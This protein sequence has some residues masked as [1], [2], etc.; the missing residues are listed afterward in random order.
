[1]IDKVW[2][3]VPARELKIGNRAQN[4]QLKQND[5]DSRQHERT[6]SEIVSHKPLN[7]VY[8]QQETLQNVEDEFTLLSRARALDQEALTQIHDRYYDSIYRYIA[9]R[10]DDPHMAEDLA[11]DVFLR[12][13]NA[14]QDKHAPQNT[15]RGWLYGVASNVVKEYYRKKRRAK[16]TEL[17]ESTPHDGL[18]PEQH[19]D[20]ALAS[21]ELRQA[22]QTLTEDQQQVLALRFGY[23]MPIR[24]VAETMDKSEGSVKMLQVRAIAAL[25]RTMTQ[26]EMGASQ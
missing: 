13:L 9:F 15:I 26:S 16:L 10:V 18:G 22:V 2:R 6:A 24:E 7:Q 19:L 5:S 14:L 8:S 17:D 20:Q 25:T 11:S 12:L 21:E 1:M 4:A 3:G 23:G